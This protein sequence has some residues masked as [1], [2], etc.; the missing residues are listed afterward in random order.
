MGVRTWSQ[1]RT[2][3][4]EW[5]PSKWGK[6]SENTCAQSGRPWGVI[7]AVMCK[8][9]LPEIEGKVSNLLIQEDGRIL[10]GGDMVI[11]VQS[12]KVNREYK[13]I[14]RLN[15]DGSVDLSFQP[16]SSVVDS[17]NK[18][19]G[20]VRSIVV[21]PDGRI[22]IGG[23]FGEFGGLIRAGLLRLDHNGE[24]DNSI[25]FGLGANGSVRSIGVQNDFRII[26]GQ[27]L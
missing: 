18:I 13:N 11:T 12:D 2:R 7:L 14:G 22:I 15:R 21:Q 5:R 3:C 16:I 27:S 6:E 25:N 17:K 19:D 24:L 20:I 23:D 10:I 1:R 9:V 8:S 26:I 4:S